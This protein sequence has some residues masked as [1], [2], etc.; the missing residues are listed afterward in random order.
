MH[1]KQPRGT[2]PS[3]SSPLQHCKEEIAPI[4]RMRE[5]EIDSVTCNLKVAALGSTVPKA[6]TICPELYQTIHST[7]IHSFETYLLQ[8]SVPDTK[9][10]LTITL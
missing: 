10:I 4:I 2:V 5:R 8:A 6:L 3:C 1:S 7:Y 9:L